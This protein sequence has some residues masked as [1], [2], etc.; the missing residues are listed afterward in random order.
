MSRPAPSAGQP[1]VDRMKPFRETSE[2]ADATA[3]L[4]R[5]IGRRVAQEDP[6]SLVELLVLD[7]ALELAWRTA[8][9]GLREAGCTDPEIGRVLGI[10]KQAVGQRWPRAAEAAAR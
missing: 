4:V 8:V 6:R 10:T 7:A 1:R 2:V 3:R 9:E 5:A